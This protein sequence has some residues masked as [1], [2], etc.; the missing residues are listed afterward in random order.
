ML[1]LI[2]EGRHLKEVADILNITTRTA[3][4]HKYRIMAMVGAHSNA[5]FVRYAVK[6]HLVSA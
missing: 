3:T 5:E 6:N 4:F 1:Q 2:A